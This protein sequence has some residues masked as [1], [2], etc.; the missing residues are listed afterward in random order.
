VRAPFL[1]RVLHLGCLALALAGCEGQFAAPGG[2]QVGGAGA[3]PSQGTGGAGGGA[4]IVTEPPLP[5]FVPAVLQG[6][7]LLSWQ[8]HNAVRELLGPAAAAV[9]TPPAD[10]PIN[11]LAAIGAAQLSLGATAVELYEESAFKAAQAALSSPAGKAALLGCT[12]ARFDDATCLGGFV[13]RFGKKVFRRAL[14]AQERAGWLA[15]GTAA[16]T[17]YQAFDAGLEF[18]IA[19]L[20]QSP[21]FLYRF[22]LGQADPA[23][24]TRQRLTG[25]ELATRLAFFLT[26]TTPSEAL[27]V[28]AQTDQLS[29]ADGVRQQAQALLESNPAGAREALTAFW[30]EHFELERLKGLS[31]DSTAFP[32]FDAALAQSMGQESEFFLEDLVFDSDSDLRGLFDADFTYLDARLAQHYGTT[33]PATGFQRVPVPPN[34]L[35]GGLFTQGAWLALFGNPANSSPTHRGKFLR[36]KLLCQPVDAPPPSVST[37]LPPSMPGN[38]TT[39]R[40]RLQA[41]VGNPNCSGCH[42]KM[43]PLGFAFENFDAVGTFRTTDSGKRVDASGAFDGVGYADVRGLM[44]ALKADPAV[45]Q[46]LARTLFRQATGHVETPGEARPLKAIGL[47]FASKGYKGKQLLIEIAAS[48]AFRFGRLPEGVTP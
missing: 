26:G 30:R 25:E 36:E 47:G 10:S 15:V 13:E 1:D 18:V 35:R 19:G 21:N 41:H 3:G 4:V 11:G 39:L 20:L 9:V 33:A 46:C 6:R 7:L 44:G 34:Q 24:S 5:D 31:K 12:P 17:A 27:L 16:A 28:A 22:E 23:D 38:A 42:A 32:T 2:S 8:Y 29:T 37:T 14:S 48:E 45:M 43:D 40:E